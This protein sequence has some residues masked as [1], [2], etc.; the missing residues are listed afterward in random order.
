MAEDTDTKE[1]LSLEA[2]NQRYLGEWVLLKV[3]QVDN[4]GDVTQGLV[5]HHS[6]SGA[7]LARATKKAHREE[8]RCQLYLFIAGTR[9]VSNDEFREALAR[10]ARE[11]YVNARW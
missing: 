2:V 4:D 6:R 3:T 1:I 10:A 11:A 5:A 9:R 8:P 7:G